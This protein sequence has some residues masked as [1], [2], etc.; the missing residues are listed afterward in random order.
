MPPASRCPHSGP[1]FARAIALVKEDHAYIKDKVGCEVR[2]VGKGKIFRSPLS[3]SEVK[4]QY[5]RPVVIELAAPMRR[6]DARGAISWP[7]E[8]FVTFQPTRLEPTFDG[9]P[10]VSKIASKPQ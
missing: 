10:T 5:N 8:L 4:E 6:T 1:R 9:F 2:A 3:T 7:N